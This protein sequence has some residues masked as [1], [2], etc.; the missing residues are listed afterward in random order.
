MSA[1]LYFLF[2]AASLTVGLAYPIWRSYKV[3]EAKKFDNELIQWLS[4]WVI[5]ACLVKVEELLVQVGISFL[6]QN[7]LY[8]ALKLLFII[9]MIHPRYQGAIYSYHSHTEKLFKSRED[10]IRRK[11]SYL[12]T[13]VPIKVRQ[14][15]NK[16]LTLLARH[17]QKNSRLKDLAKSG[18]HWS[19]S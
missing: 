9:W 12:L 7:Y 13:L 15:L 3:V 2:D 14:L 1:A 16:A 18:E 17:N 19:N 4:F 11:A 6:I 5:Q 10:K 8:K